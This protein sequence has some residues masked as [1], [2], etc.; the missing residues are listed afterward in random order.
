M[1]VVTPYLKNWCSCLPCACWS[2][3]GIP[4]NSSIL[5]HIISRGFNGQFFSLSDIWVKSESNLACLS[6]VWVQTRP[7]KH[8][9]ATSSDLRQKRVFVPLKPQAGTHVLHN[10]QL[11]WIEDCI[12]KVNISIWQSLL[13]FNA[14]PE[15]LTSKPFLTSNWQFWKMT[16]QSLK[17]FLCPLPTNFGQ[18]CPPKSALSQQRWICDKSA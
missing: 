6:K 9:V 2:W 17:M 4:W 10:V 3:Q 5:Y 15:P 13:V 11:T 7:K 8:L 14:S 16:P 12:T 18:K 1:V